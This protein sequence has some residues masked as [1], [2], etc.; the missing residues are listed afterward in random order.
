MEQHEHKKTRRSFLV[1]FGIVGVMVIAAGTFLK[2]IIEF[3]HP[4]S[5][6]KKFH[7]YLVAKT[8]EI[9]IGQAKEITLGETPVF[10][11]HLEDT[12]KAYSGICTH[13]GCLIRWEEKDEHFYCPCHQGY[14]DKTGKVTAGP[15]P[16]P[17]DEF[18]VE[19]EDNLVY[20]HIPEKMK[21]PW[22]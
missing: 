12:Y 22:T 14:F 20:M 5:Q 17:L 6:E 7:K 3:I 19:V 21:G 18:V 4:G 1:N 15:P 16:R 10:I 8:G 13:L 9:E 2:S 11:V